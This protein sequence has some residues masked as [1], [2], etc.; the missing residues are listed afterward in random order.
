M[1]LLLILCLYCVNSAILG[2]TSGGGGNSDQQT[3]RVGKVRVS[4]PDLVAT[5]AS[6]ESHN[7]KGGTFEAEAGTGSLGELTATSLRKEADSNARTDADTASISSSSV[8]TDSEGDIQLTGRVWDSSS[9]SST[10]SLTQQVASDL[11]VNVSDED[12]SIS[13]HN[14]SPSSSSSSV[15]S[16]VASRIAQRRATSAEKKLSLLVDEN[17]NL[18]SQILDLQR[19]I[20]DEG[21]EA[22]KRLN[23]VEELK[24]ISEQRKL[25]EIEMEKSTKDVE[26]AR[27]AFEAADALREAARANESA[28]LTQLEAAQVGGT[29]LKKNR[30]NQILAWPAILLGALKLNRERLESCINWKQNKTS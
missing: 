25:A 10:S 11:P 12:S 2:S 5:S 20:E 4:F 28:I 22:S 14:S 16:S 3:N 8:T 26:A 27:L 29:K 18:K 1:K 9:S 7:V 30:G 15:T 19:T 6:G 23:H 24:L 13:S 21:F 17:R